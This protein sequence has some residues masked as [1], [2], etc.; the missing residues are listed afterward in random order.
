L[1]FLERS[2]V[3]GG[4]VVVVVATALSLVKATSNNVLLQQQQQQQR[5]QQHHHHA[6]LNMHTL[7]QVHVT[8]ELHVLHDSNCNG[9]ADD[10]KSGN[11]VVIPSRVDNDNNHFPLDDFKQR[12]WILSIDEVSM[13]IPTTTAT[14]D[15][16]GDD[17]VDDDG[18]SLVEMDKHLSLSWSKMSFLNEDDDNDNVSAQASAATTRDTVVWMGTTTV[19][20]VLPLVAAAQLF[21]AEQHRRRPDQTPLTRTLVVALWEQQEENWTQVTTTAKTG[22]DGDDDVD[23]SR[24]RWNRIF[25]SRT[26][27]HVPRIMVSSVVSPSSQ[28]NTRT[29]GAGSS[30]SMNSAATYTRVDIQAVSTIPTSISNSHAHRGGSVSITANELRT[31]SSFFWGML[32]QWGVACLTLM[33]AAGVISGWTTRKQYV[34]WWRHRLHHQHAAAAQDEVVLDDQAEQQ[35]ELEDEQDASSCSSS[36]AEEDEEENSD[37]DNDDDGQEDEQDSDEEEE[38]A[39]DDHDDESSPHDEFAGGTHLPRL[40]EDSSSSNH[41]LVP[42]GAFLPPPRFRSVPQS[43]VHAMLANDRA[44]EQQQQQDPQQQ[45]DAD[46]DNDIE[47]PPTMERL[48]VRPLPSQGITFESEMERFNRLN[49]ASPSSSSNSGIHS[50]GGGSTSNHRPFG[51]WP[52]S[53]FSNATTLPVPLSRHHYQQ[54]LPAPPQQQGQEGAGASVLAWNDPLFTMGDGTPA[55]SLLPLPPPQPVPSPWTST[56]AKNTTTATS[57]SGQQQPSSSSIG[58]AQN[59]AGRESIPSFVSLAASSQAAAASTPLLFSSFFSPVAVAGYDD[60]TA[61]VTLLADQ[62]GDGKKKSAAV[63]SVSTSL[64][65][66]EETSPLTDASVAAGTTADSTIIAREQEN[67]AATVRDSQQT[68]FEKTSPV[69][70]TATV[71]AVNLKE[72]IVKVVESKTIV[73]ATTTSLVN[74]HD[75]TLAQTSVNATLPKKDALFAEDDSKAS[76]IAKSEHGTVEGQTVHRHHRPLLSQLKS[77]P[78]TKN[79]K[80][81]QSAEETNERRGLKRSLDDIDDGHLD[82]R[83]TDAETMPLTEKPLAGTDHELVVDAACLGK[84]GPRRLLS[85]QTSNASEKHESTSDRQPDRSNRVSHKGPSTSTS[86]YASTLTPDS[87]T[88]VERLDDQWPFTKSSDKTASTGSKAKAKEHSVKSISFEELGNRSALPIDSSRTNTMTKASRVTMKQTEVMQPRKSLASTLATHASVASANSRHEPVNGLCTIDN[89]DREIGV[90][91]LHGPSKPKLAVAA[92]SA[93]STKSF[94]GDPDGS[95]AADNSVTDIVVENM[96]TMIEAVVSRT[97]GSRSAPSEGT[98]DESVQIVQP[99]PAQGELKSPDATLERKTVIQASASGPIENG[100]QEDDSVQVVDPPP[101]FPAVPLDNILPDFIPSISLRRAAQ[102]VQAPVWQMSAA[103]AE[104]ITSSVIQPSKP[105]SRRITRAARKARRSSKAAVGSQSQSTLNSNSGKIKREHVLHQD[106][107]DATNPC[108][109]GSLD[110]VPV[111]PANL[112]SRRS[113]EKRLAQQTENKPSNSPSG[114]QQKKKRSRPTQA[115]DSS[116]HDSAENDRPPSP[117]RKKTGHSVANEA[118]SSR[119][120]EAVAFSPPG[121]PTKK[122]KAVSKTRPSTSEAPSAPSKHRKH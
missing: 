59:D 88:T 65:G 105:R 87:H 119:I 71:V 34:P 15:N 2:L 114:Q 54:Q 10:A 95:L 40:E 60:S 30:S 8:V 89:P 32:L 112:R 116:T 63:S 3:V 100:E 35:H 79:A 29:V 84:I 97:E 6:L 69:A 67:A 98:D 26:L 53:S 39:R 113:R 45:D 75:A 78:S 73:V 103:E 118:A 46:T 47:L 86:T 111:P 55:G 7:L 23:D 96:E 22:S 92:A 90:E 52:L 28:M 120:S 80:V 51:S 41:H 18:D 107:D 43:S 58:A 48:V 1:F 94:A 36:R 66:E 4:L 77:S 121:A 85:C 115:H 91:P 19:S 74:N 101:G 33:L 27:T 104:T 17:D 25:L 68:L 49:L 117:K 70:A 108:D 122:M 9:P 31:R 62:I 72:D 99:P 57:A 12:Q 50:R 38:E 61:A 14:N 81:L 16:D 83:A 64:F 109:D 44:N 24:F 106:E 37:D 76:S 93:A 110:S 82:I 102:R 5:Q 42:G 11:N 21:H 20:I 56:S 13:T